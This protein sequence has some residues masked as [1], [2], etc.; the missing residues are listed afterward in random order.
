MTGEVGRST[1]LL[2]YFVVWSLIKNSIEFNRGL[3][4]F[5][6]TRCL[7]WLTK[8]APEFLTD[9]FMSV[10]ITTEIITRIPEPN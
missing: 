5:L 2:L 4:Y 7:D 6:S 3:E 8:S 10:S 1:S 9:R